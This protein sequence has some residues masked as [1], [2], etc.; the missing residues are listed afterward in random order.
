MRRAKL[1]VSALFALLFAVVGCSS[2]LPPDVAPPR[3]STP[4][5]PYTKGKPAPDAQ[6]EPANAYV[7][8]ARAESILAHIGAIEGH[9]GMAFD[10]ARTAHGGQPDACLQRALGDLGAVDQKARARRNDLR[11]AAFDDPA[12]EE[13]I[14]TDLSA[15][16]A[17][18]DQL[19]RGC[20]ELASYR[21]SEEYNVRL[22]DLESRV[23]PLKDQIGKP[24]TD[25]S[26]MSG[27]I[28]L[29][30]AL[31]GAPAARAMSVGR[32]FTKAVS[33]L[34]AGKP[35]VRTSA[36]PPPPPTPGPTSPPPPPATAPAASPFA[37]TAGHDASMLLRSAQLAL[38]V[39][40][41]DKKMDA[42]QA[43]ATELGGY[44]A[45]RGDRE[46]TVR[47]PRER[48][49][50]AL[51][52]IEG[53]GDVL[54]RSVAAEDVT[55]Q[56]VDLELRLKNAQAVRARLEKLLETASVKDAVEIHKELTK[57]TE[58][59]ERLSGKL[60]LLRDRIAFSTITVT[61]ERTEPQR[62][63][64]QALLPIAWMR[65]MGLGPLLQVTR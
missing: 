18:A 25:V 45:L 35:Q 3:A 10:R 32:S 4:R 40:E 63:R 44:L 14:F 11:E 22:R 56:Y 8:D 59:V 23:S 38:A 39:F 48:F 51:R 42:V 16:A 21:G 60:K 2:T 1:A 50:E 46:L 55:D 52:R 13:A 41:V 34:F 9:A 12:V 57:I 5:V 54:H 61:F 33:G 53:V 20:T 58:E 19:A 37:G 65:T 24:S 49:D 62:L 47:V 64:S 43:I 31:A 27:E 6:P 17:R 26:L 15:L 36:S 7:R 30:G 28:M 29:T